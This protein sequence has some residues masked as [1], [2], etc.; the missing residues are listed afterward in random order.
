MA[1][2]LLKTQIN[3]GAAALTATVKELE[4]RV[5]AINQNSL[6]AADNLDTSANRRG[7]GKRGPGKSTKQASVQLKVEPNDQVFLQT[8]TTAQQPYPAV[9]PTHTTQQQP[10]SQQIAPQPQLVSSSWPFQMQ[11]P[12]AP[13]PL[14][15]NVPQLIFPPQSSQ[16]R[17]PIWGMDQSGTWG[18]HVI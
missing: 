17:K 2:A 15:P 12:T 13:T 1:Y 8:Q 9:W 14:A 5:E 6:T 7:K 18:W 4:K 10:I 3:F 16:Q 11:Y